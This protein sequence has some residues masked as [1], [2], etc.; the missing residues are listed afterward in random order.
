[1]ETR[2]V[3][4][5]LIFS[6]SA[7]CLRK[8]RSVCFR[9]R[10]ISTQLRDGDASGRWEGG[11]RLRGVSPIKLWTSYSALVYF[12]VETFHST[13]DI[14]S[15]HVYCHVLACGFFLLLSSYHIQL[16]SFSCHLYFYFENVTNVLHC[17]KRCSTSF[18]DLYCTANYLFILSIFINTVYVTCWVSYLKMTFIE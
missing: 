10:R 4:S 2:R 8:M 3:W 15:V 9:K 17:G 18:M 16:F 5:L 6:F 14:K 7:E 1:M 12:S 11:A 13:V